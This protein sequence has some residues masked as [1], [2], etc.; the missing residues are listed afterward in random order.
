MFIDTFLIM[1]LQKEIKAYERT[2][3][4]SVKKCDKAEL[5][6]DKDTCRFY[7]LRIQGLEHLIILNQKHIELLTPENLVG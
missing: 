5:I 3:A 2:M 1:Q 4:E 7:R 6:K